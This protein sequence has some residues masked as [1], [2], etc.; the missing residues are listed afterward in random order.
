MCFSRSKKMI[1]CSLAPVALACQSLLAQ[2]TYM[3]RDL[4][5]LTDLGGRSDSGPVGINRFGNVAGS[6]VT[7]GTYRA[8]IYT[9]SWQ[10]LGTLGGTES[11]AGG[12]N[13]S[14]WVVGNADTADGSTKAF[15]WNLG[16]TNGEVGN[17]QMINLGTLGGL[18]SEA[19][20]INEPG[21]ITGYSDVPAKP[22]SQ[23]HAFLYSGSKMQDIGALLPQLPNSFGYAVNNTGHVTGAAYNVAYAAPHVFFFNGSAAVD[24]G[25]FGGL[26][27]TALALNDSDTIAGYFTTTNNLDRAFSY[28]GGKLTDLGSLGGD[29]SYA[30]GINNSNL[31]V[32]GSFVDSQNL[33]YHAFVWRGGAMEDLNTLLDASGSGWSLTEARAVNEVGQITGVGLLS[34]VSHGFLLTPVSSNTNSTPPVLNVLLGSGSNL[35]IQFLSVLGTP[36]TLQT[37][38]SAASGGWVNTGTVLTG[39]GG[40]LSVTNSTATSQSTFYRVEVSGP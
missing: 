40:L 21:Q 16:S 8:I 33:V 29:Y 37:N 38:S 10:Q 39:T 15:A 30:R 13:D 17:P 25:T 9:S 36:Y 20:S 35:V 27:A 26:A 1:C 3:V 23:Q 22:T 5:S 6:N 4:G 18:V 28:R 12:I 11:L 14:G 19:F 24:L 7:N 2:T 31:I 32:G 34:G